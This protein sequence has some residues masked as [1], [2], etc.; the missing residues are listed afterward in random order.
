[1]DQ[2][3]AVEKGLGAGTTITSLALGVATTHP[4]SA[5]LSFGVGGAALPK[6]IDPCRLQ[7]ALPELR[8]QQRPAAQAAACEGASWAPA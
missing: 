7:F 8:P 5:T 2:F 1:L 6:I 4:I 3:P